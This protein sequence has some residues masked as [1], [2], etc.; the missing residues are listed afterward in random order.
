MS[1][2]AKLI[3]G[4]H[5]GLGHQGLAAL[6]AKELGID[7][8]KLTDGDLLLFINRRGDKLKVLG[9]KDR[10]IGYIRAPGGSK[11]MKDA[12]QYLPQTFG[13]QGFSYERAVRIALTKRLG[14]RF[15]S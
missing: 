8:E 11:L 14:E 3:E 12:L 13:G 9:G 7:V 5:M 4:V 10:V 15:E 6:S 1:R 2:I